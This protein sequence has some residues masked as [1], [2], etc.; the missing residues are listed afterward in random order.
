MTSQGIRKIPVTVVIPCYRCQDTI[1]RA[2]QSV[3]SQSFLPT[4]II[5]VDDASDDC[6]A[7][8]MVLEQLRETYTSCFQVKVL[9]HRQNLGLA[10]ARNTGWN[11]AEQPY[12]A[13]LDAD[14]AWHPKRLE[15][16]FAWMHQ[17]PDA[18]VIGTSY[19]WLRS[20]QKLPQFPERWGAKRIRFDDLLLSNPF[21][22]SSIL[23]RQDLPLRFQPSKRYCEDYLLWLM[24]AHDG[25]Q[26]YLLSLPLA[27]GYKPAFGYRGLSADLW[28][29]EVNELANYITLLRERMLSRRAWALATTWSM[30]KFIRRLMICAMKIRT[31]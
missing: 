15:I 25:H 16:Q 20:D 21:N 19:V 26:L 23:V 13:F 14:D 30:A 7:T 9:R 27:Y 6:G 28:A 12:V 22:A 17:R 18:A 2:V 3:V 10:S 29:M 4:E 5:L 24:L 1:E 11:I 8:A 31:F